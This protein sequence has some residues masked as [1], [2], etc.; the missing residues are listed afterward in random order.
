MKHASISLQ[1]NPR[2]VPNIVDKGALRGYIGQIQRIIEGA[3]Q[4]P[5]A[6][7]QAGREGKV[8]IQF[9]IFRN[10]KVGNIKLLTRTPYPNLNREA[11]DAVKRAAPFSS[12]PNSLPGQSVN[13]ILPFRFELH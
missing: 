10:G 11:M 2:D 9:T 12:F 13:V 5:E 6:S 4:Y 3:K 1:A 7:R 8:K